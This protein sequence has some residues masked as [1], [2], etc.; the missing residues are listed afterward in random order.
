MITTTI[1]NFSL[2]QICRSGQC[3]RMSEAGENTYTVIAGNRY[4][5]VWQQGEE[6]RF[7]C[8]K[9]EFE[10]FW[11]EYFDLEND[12]VFFDLP[13]EQY[14]ADQAVYSEPL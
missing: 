7:D 4:L 11:K 1:P 6:C 2:G 8:T 5:E 9:A 12:R 14:C 3:F 13:A 10:G